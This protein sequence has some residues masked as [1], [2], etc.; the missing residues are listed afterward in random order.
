MA[1]VFY[2]FSETVADPDLW[3]HIA[4][5]RAV[6]TAGQVAQ[7]DPFS[8]VTAGAL[9]LN[10]EWLSEVIFYLAFAAAGPPGLILLKTA[11]S[12]LTFGLLYRHLSRQGLTAVRA[13]LIVLA[14]VHFFLMTLVTVRTLIL[15]YPLLLLVLIIVHRMSRSETRWAWA[16]PPLFAVWANL[17]PGFLAGLGILAI[18]SLAELMARRMPAT[19]GETPRAPSGRLILAVLGASAA[20]TALNPYGLELW[21]FLLR[22]ATVPRP[23]IT[24]WQPLTLMTR[25]G[26]VYLLYVGAVAAS[27]LYSRR[28]RRP[29]AVAVLVVA[30]LLPLVAIRHTPLSA[31]IIAVFGGEHVNDALDRLSTRGTGGRSVRM[32]PAPALPAALLL[33]AAVVLAALSLPHFSCIRIEPRIGGSYPARAVE[34]IRRSG[35]RGNLAI[36]FDWGE[37]ALYR[38]GPAVKVSVDGRRETMYRRDVYLENLNFMHGQGDWDA[39][40]R[41]HDTHL[42]LV[43]T[44][45]STFNL[46]KL[47]PGW[48]LLHEDPLAGL[49]GREGLPAA[50]AIRGTAVPPLPHDGAGLCFP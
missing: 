26:L 4:F 12:L 47:R 20:A 9:W 44:G 13:G 14:V 40:L 37:Y 24:E 32:R 31:L 29:A 25:Y 50:E 30:A 23:D 34:L 33:A 27:L 7:P 45:S 38:L 8:Y 35:A 36:H 10:H 5:G 48:R 1:L 19:P 49:F 41:N 43:K 46:M 2:R 6:W 17:H 42:A 3:G 28:E 15:S 16:L 11:L 21:S 22:T 39:I 18:W